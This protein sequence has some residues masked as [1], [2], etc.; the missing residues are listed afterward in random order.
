MDILYFFSNN[1]IIF[2]FFFIIKHTTV[3]AFIHKINVQLIF[4]ISDAISDTK[5]IHDVNY[6]KYPQYSISTYS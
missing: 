6:A 1:S 2:L 3:P 5:L 4:D